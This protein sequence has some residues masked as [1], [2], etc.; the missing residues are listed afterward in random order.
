MIKPLVAVTG[1]TGRLGPYVV[2]EL[3]RKGYSLRLLVRRPAEAQRLFRS[4]VAQKR[5]TVE[6]SDLVLATEEDLTKALRDC[7]AI[8][9]LAALVD[10]AQPWEAFMLANFEVTKKLVAAA[11]HSEVK[12]FVYASSIAV[13]GDPNQSNI[14]EHATLRP[15]TPYGW[16]K[17]FAE[18]AVKHSGLNYVILR[19]GIIYGPEVEEGFVTMAKVVAR[20]QARI[21]GRGDNRVPLVHA[22]DVAN[23]FGLAVSSS[24]ASHQTFNVCGPEAT[25]KELLVMLAKNLRAGPVEKHTPVWLAYLAAFVDTA[26]RRAQGKPARLLPDY[27]RV[28][29]DDRSFSTRHLEKVLG[30]KARVSPAQGIVE[31]VRWLNGHDRAGVP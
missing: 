6:R 13:Y 1:A 23:A 27:V 21:I 18:D 8:V 24:K 28:L 4:A 5:V 11:R 31:F 10:F 16:S 19:P 7:S 15:T 22:S 30:W 29:S 20:G 14:S 12:R 3:L 25:Q 2:R 17:Y 9:H 26:I